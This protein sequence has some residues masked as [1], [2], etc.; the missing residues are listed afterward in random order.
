MYPYNG[1]HDM[2]VDLDDFLGHILKISG[3]NLFKLD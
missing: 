2:H 3:V 1:C